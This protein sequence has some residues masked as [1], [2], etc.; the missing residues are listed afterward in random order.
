MAKSDA[1]LVRRWKD[2]DREA[3]GELY[4]RYCAQLASLAHRH[5]NEKFHSRMDT[6]DLLQTAFRSIL[7]ALKRQSLEFEEDGRFWKWML[8]V[9]LNKIYKKIKAERAQIR[10]PHREES[11]PPDISYEQ[12]VGDRLSR[13]PGV[14]DVVVF[15]EMLEL[16]HGRLEGRQREVFTQRVAGRQVQEIADSLGVNEKTIRRDLIEIRRVAAG[17]LGEPLPAGLASDAG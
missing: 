3:G 7:I 12:F 2:G 11:P 6:A 8:S 17:V 13:G 4:E 15:A 5:L 10:T 1:D 9:A 14:V 16:L